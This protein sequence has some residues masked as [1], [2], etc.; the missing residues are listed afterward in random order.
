MDLFLVA[1]IDFRTGNYPEK[2][3]IFSIN[4]LPIRKFLIQNSSTLNINSG[5][6]LDTMNGRKINTFAVM[7]ILLIAVPE[8]VGHSLFDKAHPTN[9]SINTAISLTDKI[10]NDPKHD[11][12]CTLA[13]NDDPSDAK[14]ARAAGLEGKYGSYSCE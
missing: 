13:L 12:S 14:I 8:I 9:S 10:N 1:N 5:C 6:Y 7:V 2:Y 4:L 3:E 11:L